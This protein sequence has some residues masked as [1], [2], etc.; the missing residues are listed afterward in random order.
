MSS[1]KE[2]E[3]SGSGSGSS[4]VD[5]D[6][7]EKLEDVERGIPF[8]IMSWQQGVKADADAEEDVMNRGKNE[9][10]RAQYEFG[11]RR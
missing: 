11:S 4:G 10:T 7:S 3:G 5:N 8:S 2:G 9:T 1:S 6:V